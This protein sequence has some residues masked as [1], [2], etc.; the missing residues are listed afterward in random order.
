MTTLDTSPS[1]ESLD[2]DLRGELITPL[3]TGYDEARRIWNG[4]FDMHPL[5]IVRALGA[6]EV[7]T[8]VRFAREAG[9]RL[10]VRGGGHSSAGHSTCDGGIVLDLSRMKG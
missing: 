7:V 8:G 2:R 3:H 1:L 9:A 4:M 5:A 6:V 10:A